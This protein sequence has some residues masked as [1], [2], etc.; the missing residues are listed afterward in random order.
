MQIN[1][2]VTFNELGYL[3][4]G[5]H[6]KEPAE[7]KSAFVDNFPNSSS[8]KE[9]FEG[10]LKFCKT[11]MALGIKNFVQWLDGSFCTSKENPNDIDVV[12]FLDYDKLNA[13]PSEN[14]KLLMDIALN[15]YS[16]ELFKCDSYV[17]LVYPKGHNDYQQY[18]T[19]RMYWRGVWGFDR[20]DKPKGIIRVI[21]GKG[22]GDV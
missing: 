18:L 9:I 19:K 3:P 13:L 20:Y 11:L 21:Y 7:I 1:S 15:P 5:F 10:Y 6:N 4:S 14:Q 17:V 12:T 8:R 2:L 16:K 22:V